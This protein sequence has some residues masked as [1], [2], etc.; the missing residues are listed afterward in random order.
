[1]WIVRPLKAAIDASTKPDSLSVSVWMATCTSNSSATLR[2]QSIAAGVVPQSSCSLKPIA[3]PASCS[4]SP[5]GL[6]EFPLPRKPKFSGKPSVAWS[7]IRKWCAPGEQ[8]VAQ[9]PV[10][11]PVPPPT[12]EVRPLA[13]A[14]KACCG[15]MKWTWVSIPPAV[16]DQPFGG[17]D[18]GGHADDHPR[19]DALHHVGIARLADAGDPAVLDADVG[20]VDAGVVDDQGVGDHAIQRVGLAHARGLAHAVAE[21]LAAAEFALVAVDGEVVLDFQPQFRVAEANAVAG[22]RSVDLGVMRAFDFAGHS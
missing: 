15:Q 11:G 1:M 2:Q 13:R 8:V 5:S 18:F 20:L 19:I 16:S 6:A 22:R 7:I 17:D 14:S 10:A 21:H 4:A 3:P 9:V 12:I